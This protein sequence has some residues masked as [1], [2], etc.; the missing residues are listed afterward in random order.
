MEVIYSI[1]EFFIALWPLWVSTLTVFLAWHWWLRY[2]HR[3]FIESIQWVTLEIRVPKEV[4]KS[5][6][7]M[8]LALANALSQ[9]GGVGTWVQ[10]YWLGN[11]VFWFSLEIVSLGG[12]VRFFI[13]T[14][15]K[16]KMIIEN[17]LYAQYPQAE[18]T[19]VPDYTIDMMGKMSREPWTI[20]GNTFALSKEDPYPIKTYVD[21]NLDQA[22]EKLK[23]EQQVDPITP[24]IELLGSIRPTEQM[25]FQ[26]LVRPAQKR[27]SKPGKWFAKGDWKDEGKDLIKKIKKDLVPGEESIKQLTQYEKDMI[28]AIER[29]I[30][31]Q[32]FDVGIRAIY[33]AQKE[34]FDSNRIAAMTGAFKQ[35]ST[36]HLNGFKIQSTTGF[37][38]PWQDPTGRRAKALK[39]EMFDA[40]IR[41]SYFYEPYNGDK[42]FVLNAE[43]LATIFHLPGAV[44]ET[45]QFK[46]IESTKAEPPVDLPV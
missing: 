30:S 23:P 46:R 27:Y 15:T 7:A 18:I 36:P 22:P 6:F 42:P 12:D 3:K 41:R 44:S 1:L 19:E 20:W 34:S 31:K 11:L 21:Y 17:Q 14:S 35:Y 40:Y 9:T 10:K 13:R 45:P 39:Q 29:N 28:T 33:L 5:P 2:L 4:S 26:I 24:M 8:E 32:G 25:W 38:Y 16:F 43:E 37:D